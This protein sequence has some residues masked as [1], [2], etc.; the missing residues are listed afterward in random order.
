MLEQIKVSLGVGSIYSHGS[1]VQFSVRSLKELSRIINHFDKYPLITQK[2]ADYLLFREVTLMLE[3]KEHLT[4][5]GMAKVVALK[6]SLNRGLSDELKVAFPNIIPASRLTI[7]S[8]CVSDP[9]W[10]AGFASGE[11]SFNISIRKS[12]T[13]LSGY[14]VHLKFTL[15]QHWRDEQLLIS[16]VDYL[17][18][19]KVYKDGETFQYQVQKFTD[20]TEYIIP[21]FS[22]Y[23]IIGVKAQD[24]HD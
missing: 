20:H 12:N 5:Q 23:P 10:L 19:G 6:A 3:G 18:C 7:K 11:G 2:Q 24:Y 16:L 15:T 9:N 4:T 8:Y 14:Q 22:K 13:H 17:G 1:Q 21:F